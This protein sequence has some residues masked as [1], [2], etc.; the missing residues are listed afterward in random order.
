MQI[1]LGTEEVLQEARCWTS[2]DLS[3][4]PISNTSFLFFSFFRFTFY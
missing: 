1:G 4:G 3:E 2:N